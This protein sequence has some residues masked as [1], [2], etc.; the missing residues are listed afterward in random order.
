MLRDKYRVSSGPYTVDAIANYWRAGKCTAIAG[1]GAT[2]VPRGF[3]RGTGFG[4][5]GVEVSLGLLRDG[6]GVLAFVFCGHVDGGS[7][8]YVINLV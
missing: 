6:D 3:G 5:V 8:E 7:G 1:I 4:C 2:T